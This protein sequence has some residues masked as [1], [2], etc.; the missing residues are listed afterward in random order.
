MFFI[1][2]EHFSNLKLKQLEKFHMV[3]SFRSMQG[4]I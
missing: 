4:V 3:L 2:V 1:D